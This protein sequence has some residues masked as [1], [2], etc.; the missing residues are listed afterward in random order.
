MNSILIGLLFMIFINPF[1]DW[2]WKNR[3]LIINEDV[4]LFN[5]FKKME[6][7][8]K[9]RDMII[10]LIQKSNLYSFPQKIDINIDKV[11]DHFS[12]NNT[13]KSILIGKDGGTKLSKSTL[14]VKEI[15]NLIDSMPMRRQEV[16]KKSGK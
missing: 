7:E 1:S 6:T 16:R 9:D 8:V 15:F 13:Q 11:K 10:L 14:S 4:S 2:K 5:E 3:I 12:L